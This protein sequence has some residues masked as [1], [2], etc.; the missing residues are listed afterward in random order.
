MFRGKAVIHSAALL[1]SLL[2]TRLLPQM[3]PEEAAAAQSH[4]ERSA[5]SDPAAVLRNLAV[6]FS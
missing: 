2:A 3:E 4:A 1:P 6:P 5:K